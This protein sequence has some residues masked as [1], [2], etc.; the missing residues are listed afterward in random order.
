MDTISPTVQ[1]EIEQR[2]A[3]GPYGSVDEL[4]ADALHALDN[5]QDAAKNLLEK[6][7]LQG[8][9]GGDVE[10]KRMDWDDIETQAQIVIE[11]KNSR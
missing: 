3:A 5:A 8:L 6:E 7:L 9:E 11:A 4:I 10:M 1:K 2:L